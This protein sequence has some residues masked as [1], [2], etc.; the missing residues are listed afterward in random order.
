MLLPWCWSVLE[1]SKYQNQQRVD[2]E[3]SNTIAIY[4]FNVSTQYIWRRFLKWILTTIFLPATQRCEGEKQRHRNVIFFL[5]TPKKRKLIFDPLFLHSSPSFHCSEAT[6]IY[7]NGHCW[8]RHKNSTISSYFLILADVVTTI[9][10]DFPI[11]CV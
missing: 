10:Q 3:P 8:N 2:N 7:V 4:Q 6:S 11:F 9:C 1:L 5:S